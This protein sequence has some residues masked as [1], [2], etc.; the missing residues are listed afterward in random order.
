MKQN[1]SE[2]ANHIHKVDKLV[3]KWVKVTKLSL[4]SAEFH[5]KQLATEDFHTFFSSKNSENPDRVSVSVEASFSGAYGL[6][7]GKWQNCSMYQ[8]SMIE[9]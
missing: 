1:S 8:N 4:I 7:S 5:Y 9:R 3:I 6:N 2:L